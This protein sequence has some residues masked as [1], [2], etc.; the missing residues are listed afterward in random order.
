AVLND[1]VAAQ[2]QQVLE[3]GRVTFRRPNMSLDGGNGV[4]K[5]LAGDGGGHTRR[6]S[7]G[8]PPATSEACSMCGS[9]KIHTPGLVCAECKTYAC[10]KC[11]G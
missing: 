10:Y 2:P 5:A 9:T 1:G 6:A 8:T 3:A 11:E 7:L 4:V